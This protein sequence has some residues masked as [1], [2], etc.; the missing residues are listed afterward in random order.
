MS[1]NF[2]I[3][4]NQNP[5]NMGMNQN[6]MNM[7]MNQNPMNMGMNQNNMNMGMN[8]NNM[9]M[10]MNYYEMQ[11]E[12]YKCVMEGMGEKPYDDPIENLNAIMNFVPKCDPNIW[13]EYLG[14]GKTII[15]KF[16]Q[17]SGNMQLLKIGE[18]ALLKN[19]LREMANLVGI[20][21]DNEINE[22]ISFL[23]E[24]RSI[25]LE[26]ANGTL[27][28]NGLKNDSSIVLANFDLN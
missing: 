1:N 6:P 17:T 28:S 12:L 7:G 11:N 8:Q 27:K 19:A 23:V 3:D 2:G 16:G 22:K 14:E 9:N 13:S 20:K 18:N 25:K 10:G 21:N 4:F 26:N 24:G 15:I 5:M